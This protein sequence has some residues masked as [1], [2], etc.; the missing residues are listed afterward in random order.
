MKKP[1]YQQGLFPHW[2]SIPIRFR[3]LDP[4]NHVNNALFSTYYEEAR[5]KFIQQVPAFAQ[6]L[7]KGFSFVLAN[8]TID[9][10]HP[11]EYPGTL[12]IGSGIAST[13]NSSISS[14]QAIYTEKEKTLVS[15]AEAHGVWF[16]LQKQK[17]SRLP[18]IKDIDRL[19]VSL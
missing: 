14:F 13:G 10:I 1:P 6:Q 18:Q 9:F 2:S 16:D 5:I 8:I 15:V 19:T 4:L 7:E 11:A 3:D 12:L 17:P